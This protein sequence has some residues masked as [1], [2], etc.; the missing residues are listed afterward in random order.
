MEV[1]CVLVS[2]IRGLPP[3]HVR[4]L[5]AWATEALRIGIERSQTVRDLITDLEASDVIVHVETRVTLPLGV[6]G[7][8]RLAVAT[9]SHRYVRVVLLRDP[10]PVMRVAVL[11]HELQHVREIA[12]SGVRDIEGMRQLFDTIGRPSRGEGA[13]YETVA[14]IDVSH[15]VWHEVHGDEKRAAQLRAASAI[16][17]GD[18]AESGCHSCGTTSGK[19]HPAPAQSSAG[20]QDLFTG[21]SPQAVRQLHRH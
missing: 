8:T 7:T 17:R 19:G 14:A 1:L 12:R 11:G 5:D 6:A 16:M 20:E 13:A 21:R 9:A 4:T 10:L 3:N 2:L 18:G 15:V